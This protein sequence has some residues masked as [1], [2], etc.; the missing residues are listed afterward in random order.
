[1]KKTNAL[2]V[3]LLALAL[4]FAS[5]STP[6]NSSPSSGNDSGGSSGG[7]NGLPP[8]DVSDFSDCT[9]DATSFEIQN[10][11]NWNLRFMQD[12]TTVSRAAD[13]EPTFTL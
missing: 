11:T 8:M 13:N 6:N 4:I 3:I 10:N 1:M 12:E 7:G 5:C 9:V 2:T